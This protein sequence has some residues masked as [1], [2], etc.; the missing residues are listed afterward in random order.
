MIRIL[1][2]KRGGWLLLNEIGQYV[3]AEVNFAFGATLSGR[4]DVRR[5]NELRGVLELPEIRL[6]P[7]TEKSDNPPAT[8]LGG[9]PEWIQPEMPLECCGNSMT[10]LAQIDSLDVL[11]AR[12]PDSAL[13][14]VFFCPTCMNVEAH[15]QS[16]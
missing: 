7:L 8:K 3:R 9:Q 12:L 16:C 1:L 11:Q 6:V 13:I 2:P 10:F 4:A 15:M 14:Y 5:A